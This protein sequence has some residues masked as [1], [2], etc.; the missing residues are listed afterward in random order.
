[1]APVLALIAI[2]V[3]SVLMCAQGYD[4]DVQRSKARKELSKAS[5]SGGL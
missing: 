5:S 1:M 4:R 2:A 3:W